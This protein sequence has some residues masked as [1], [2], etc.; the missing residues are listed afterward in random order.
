MDTFI[1]QKRAIWRSYENK[2]EAEEPL[3]VAKLSKLQSWLYH[4]MRSEHQQAALVAVQ[5][6]A[7]RGSSAGAPA[8]YSSW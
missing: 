1:L 3:I 2:W 8:D 4:L 5:L 6:I 7:K